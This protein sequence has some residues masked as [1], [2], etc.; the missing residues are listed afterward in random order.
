MKHYTKA[1][2]SLF[3]IPE[4]F[5]D[6]QQDTFFLNYDTFT[7]NARPFQMDQNGKFSVVAGLRSLNRCEDLARVKQLALMFCPSRCQQHYTRPDSSLEGEVAEVLSLF[8]GVRKPTILYEHV[9]L[10]D[11][12]NSPIS[13][14]Q[15][16]DINKVIN[17]SSA[18]VELVIPFPSISEW[19]EYFLGQL[20]KAIRERSM[21]DN[22]SI[23]EVVWKASITEGMKAKP[24]IKHWV[25]KWGL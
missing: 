20:E 19:T 7:K 8:S 14:V 24:D 10:S 11:N 18:V 21:N 22:P 9:N 1:F 3:S 12:D 2:R 13:F 5:F 23:P 16:E 6:F 17:G 4:T 15:L 25:K